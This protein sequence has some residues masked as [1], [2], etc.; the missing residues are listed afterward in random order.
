MQ[1]SEHP[2]RFE[3][4]ATYENGCLSNPPGSVIVNWIS[5]YE[6]PNCYTEGYVDIGAGRRHIEIAEFRGIGLGSYFMSFI[7][8][9]AKHL[10]DVPVLPILLS[11][12]DAKTDEAKERRNRFWRN[13]GFVLDLDNEETFGE[14]E[15]LMNTQLT[16]PKYRLTNGWTIEKRE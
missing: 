16:E 8:K 15:P 9:W 7:I 11:A 2:E 12:E 4:K 6:P 14:S 10:P 1:I 3:I 13:L 5:I